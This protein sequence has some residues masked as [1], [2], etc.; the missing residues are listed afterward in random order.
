MKTTIEE[1]VGD[2][3]A[4]Y[5]VAADGN[6]SA[7]TEL[8][9]Q[10]VKAL[11]EHQPEWVAWM[12]IEGIVKWQNA[13]LR[14]RTAGYPEINQWNKVISEHPQWKI[15]LETLSATD[16]QPLSLV[17]SCCGSDFIFK[18][19]PMV[20]Q[21]GNLAGFRI[22][23]EASRVKSLGHT[24]LEEEV[25]SAVLNSSE[26]EWVQAMING[27]ER[28]IM[29][30]NDKHE[31]LYFNL[32]SVQD[33]RTHFGT[34]L[35][36]GVA[37]QSLGILE[38]A[39]VI[40]WL[41][42]QC[43]E[44]VTP[45]RAEICLNTNNALYWFHVRAFP[46]DF[47]NHTQRT[48]CISLANITHMK[49]VEQELKQTKQFYET[50]LNYVPADI[51]VFDLNH[52]YLFLN[53]VA[54]KNDEIRNWL[55]GKNDFDYFEMKG[56]STEIA[57]RRRAVFNEVLRTCKTLEIID[58]HYSPGGDPRYI[59]RRFFPYTEN[60]EIKLVIGYGID[61]TEVKYAEQRSKIS[62]A[63]IASALEKERELSNL[64][65]QFIHL[66]SHEFRTPMASI[67]TSMD[68]LDHY[69]K[70][71]AFDKEA[72]QPVFNRHHARIAQEIQR[73]TEI[74]NNVLLMGR[75]D[76]GRIGFNLIETDLGDFMQ[77]LMK[78][79]VVLQGGRPI[80]FQVLGKSRLVWI[81]RSLM[82]HMIKNLLA[83][84]FKYGSANEIPQVRLEFE[85]DHFKISVEDHGIGIPP[86]ELESLFQSFFRASNAE[87]IQGTGLGLVIVKK[88]AEMHQGFVSVKSELQ[89]GSVF[90]IQIPIHQHHTHA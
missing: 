88:M 38:R 36:S 74:M 13:S 60:N 25:Q 63:N 47:S 8:L 72:I 28:S 4:I 49:K 17:F 51:A 56:L 61:I 27:S 48:V 68:I 42:D 12:S 44:G 62:E 2:S 9:E 6:H 85:A 21:S 41:I 50:V 32:Q 40:H 67:Q 55:I 22:E 70:N 26:R 89:K 71:K 5:P 29:L 57:E 76:V 66:A 30:V 81:D 39:P 15:Y 20:N 83:N 79:E 52:N 69:I 86:E 16:N 87:N 45:D 14:A 78:E 24:I 11:F 84:A 23:L 77:H 43:L 54:V 82:T 37:L 33:F 31:I 58:E 18:A 10:Q 34:E 73:M 80:D 59:L 3:A 75:L 90:T 64:K 35:Q 19:I 53:P 1:I 65:T 7:K 46:L